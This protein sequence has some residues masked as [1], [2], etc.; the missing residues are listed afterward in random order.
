MKETVERQ[1]VL[2]EEYEVVCGIKT[3]VSH[4]DYEKLSINKMNEKII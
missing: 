2:E 4:L 3:L 1:E